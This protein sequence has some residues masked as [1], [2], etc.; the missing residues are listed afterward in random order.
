MGSLKI[1]IQN[2]IH[3]KNLKT[4][5]QEVRLQKN[6]YEAYLKKWEKQERTGGFQLQ[7][8]FLQEGEITFCKM[9]DCKSQ[10]PWRNVTTPY[11][12]FVSGNGIISK[13]AASKVTAFFGE[14]PE[15]DVVYCHEDVTEKENGGVSKKRSQP[16][17]KP[18]WSPDT[19]SS[20]FYFGNLFAVRTAALDEQ[21]WP[22]T[23]NYHKNLYYLVLCMTKKKPAHLLDMVLFHAF[24]SPQEEAIPVGA[25]VEYEDCKKYFW[26]IVQTDMS[27][28]K[29]STVLS[30]RY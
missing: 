20:F 10:A 29:M 26:E 30:V 22:G 5:E 13:K 11:M 21:G 12:I 6:A 18:D 14:H 1:G 23:N 25:S 8:T 15:A 19:L 9:E 27:G 16:W 4:Y 28:K 2:R 7:N 24:K 3:E 17:F